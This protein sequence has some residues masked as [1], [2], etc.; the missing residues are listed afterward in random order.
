MGCALAQ[1]EEKKDGI[2]KEK[3]RDEMLSGF[4]MTVEEEDKERKR[5]RVLTHRRHHD[6]CCPLCGTGTVCRAK[7]ACVCR[8]LSRCGVV[9]GAFEVWC[10]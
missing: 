7:H 1:P 6:T 8:V 4:E 9:C 2:G 5:M 3:R 10:I